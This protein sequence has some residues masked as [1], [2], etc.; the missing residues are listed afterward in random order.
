MKKYDFFFFFFFDI[1]LSSEDTK[2]SDFNRCQKFNKPTVTF[3]ADLEALIYVKIILKA[4]LKQR[5]V[6][7]FH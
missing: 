5:S 7:I 1:I 3:F 2:N 6:N 4:H